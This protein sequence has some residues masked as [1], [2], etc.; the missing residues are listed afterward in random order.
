MEDKFIV[1]NPELV[2]DP[3]AEDK[4]IE[5]TESLDYTDF[6]DY[7]DEYIEYLKGKDNG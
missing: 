7:V 3:S 2:K 1:A 4:F 5:W 6:C